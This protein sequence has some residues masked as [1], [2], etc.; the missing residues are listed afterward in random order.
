MSGILGRMS[1]PISVIE[2]SWHILDFRLLKL[3]TN[4]AGFRLQ[5]NVPVLGYFVHQRIGG[6]EYT[7]V[8]KL[9]INLHFTYLLSCLQ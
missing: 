3:A 7:L 1:F 5:L 2:L 6:I 4:D 9:Y 8:D